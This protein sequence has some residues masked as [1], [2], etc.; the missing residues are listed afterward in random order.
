MIVDVLDGD[1]AVID[2]DTDR[3]RQSAERHDVDG[4]AEPRQRG[5]REQNGERNLDED[6]DGRAPA[7]EEQQDHHANE[8]GGERGFADDADHR[9]L[10][11]DRLIA[12]RVQVKARRQTF[13]DPRQERLYPVDDAKRRGGTRLE[14]RHQ[15][16]ARAVDANQIGLRRGTGMHIGDVA[17]I[18][19]GAVDLLDRQ[20]VDLFQRHRAGVQSD[21]PVELAQLLVAG[22]QNQILH[23]DRVHH[24]IGRY[25]VGLHGFLIQIDLDLQNLAAIGRRDSGSGDRRKLR[26][27]EVLPKVEQ[28]HLR[29][30]LARQRQLQDGHGSRVVAQHVWWRDPGWQKLEHRLRCRS[31]LGQSG[32]DVNVLLEEYFDDAVAVERLQLDVLDIRHL[33]G[34]ITFVV[35]NDTAGHVVGQ[36]P[37][38]GPDHADDGNVDVRKNIDRHLQSR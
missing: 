35:V 8:R 12:D 6:D 10:D 16:R 23:R 19:D 22:R 13:L 15:Y 2:Q 18:D 38:V 3:E 5:Q 4:F 7:A 9:R 34:H 33:G 11:E 37:I 30:F 14:N 28:L 24:I 26:P 27:N 21:V 25:V 1:G 20:V 32:G 29:Q 17:N 31:H 36:Q